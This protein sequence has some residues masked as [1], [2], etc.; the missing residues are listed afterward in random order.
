[1]T[2][3]YLSEFDYNF[4]GTGIYYYNQSEWIV[5]EYGK[6]FYNM[7]SSSGGN[8]TWSESYADDLY[9]NVEGDTMTGNLTIER[10]LISNSGVMTIWVD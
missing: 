4:T 10:N 1:M 2:D 3:G 6:W 7:T 5:E 9:V 8:S